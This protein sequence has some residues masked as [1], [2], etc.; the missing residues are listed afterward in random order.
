MGYSL[1]L[2]KGEIAK[3]KGTAINIGLEGIYSWNWTRVGH[4][5][6]GA[7]GFGGAMGDTVSWSDK[8]V[9][10]CDA[11]NNLTLSE[12]EAGRQN[13]KWG[14]AVNKDRQVTSLVICNNVVVLG[15]AIT[16]EGKAKGFVQA[17]G[18]ESGKPVWDKTYGSK[19]AF[20]GLAVDGGKIIASFD[21]GSVTCLK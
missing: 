3:G 1:S 5:K 2:E 7:I 13:R 15:G 12:L 14:L 20:N 6:F 4:R 21:D 10:V 17:I 19:L 8:H 18:I 16:G 9:A 11:R